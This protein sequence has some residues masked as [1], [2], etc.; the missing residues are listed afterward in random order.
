M[1]AK[2]YST[3]NAII[4]QPDFEASEGENGMWTGSQT[5]KVKKGDLDSG[6][7]RPFFSRS[8][9]ATELD[10][11]N[12]SFFSFLKLKTWSVGTEVG[13]WTNIKV[14]YQGFSA[15][16]NEPTPEGE[17]PLTTYSLRGVTKSVPI[18]EHPKFQTCSDNEKFMLRLL[19]GGEFVLDETGYKIGQW[20]TKTDETLPVGDQNYM[21]FIELNNINSEYSDYE[22]L[23]DV[24]KEFA[25]R[26]SKGITTYEVGT[27]EYWV[28][29][30]SI[31][32]L[33]AGDIS[34][35][36]L[37]SPPTGDPPTPEGERDW[38]L[39]TVNQEQEGTTDP[40]YTIEIGY[41]L[42]DEGGW[43]TLLYTS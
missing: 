2:I 29:W 23:S 5:F 24:S 7:T 32:P 18:T 1:S 3:T 31:E 19:L 30:S 25:N 34:K 9:K 6:E 42:S 27:F 41:V 36:G 21:V 37:I 28:R 43:D 11:N 8:K 40:T 33:S 26:I 17:K 16:S 35:L 39:T 4:P 10:P 12:D 14:E 38:R 20:N 22:L 13:G 15:D